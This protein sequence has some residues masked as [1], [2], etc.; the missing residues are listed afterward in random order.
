MSSHLK[1]HNTPYATSD[2]GRWYRCCWDELW[3]DEW[4]GGALFG[5]VAEGVVEAREFLIVFP[6]CQAIGVEDFC[7]TVQRIGI[8]PSHWVFVVRREHL[9]N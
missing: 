2:L 6:G 3:G 8:A 7:H 1:L 9:F 5:F 4:W